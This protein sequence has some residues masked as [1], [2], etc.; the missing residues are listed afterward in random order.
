[1][2]VAL[3]DMYRTKDS[4]FPIT[5]LAS[6]TSIMT[7]II[8]SVDG[9]VAE[10]L[11]YRPRSVGQG[12][13]MSQQR[14]LFVWKSMIAH[15]ALAGIVLAETMSLAARQEQKD[16]SKDKEFS[17]TVQGPET[18][19]GLIVSAR[20]TAKEVG[21]PIYPGS[22]PYK[23]QDKDGDSPAAKVGLWGSSFGFRLVV[24]KMESKDTPRKIADYYTKALAKY[25]TVLD[26]TNAP[27]QQAKD[28]KSEKLTCGDDKPDPGGMLFK[29]GSVEKQRIVEVQPK[30][31]GTQF[32][33]LYV[34]ARGEKKKPA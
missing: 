26:C 27:P 2:E 21:L 34:E 19:A 9:A 14:A 28:E 13:K 15:C 30:G 20:A 1:M 31:N 33:L 10:L 7:R 22:T 23:E 4:E 17:V 11:S 3:P 29:A 5:W 18:D 24:L 6:A 8:S 32:K 12:E 16:T 25:G